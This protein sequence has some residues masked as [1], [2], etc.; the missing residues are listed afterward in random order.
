MI[1]KVIHVPTGKSGI[2]K[3]TWDALKNALGD[4]RYEDFHQ[5]MVKMKL[6]WGAYIT[7]SAGSG[8][9]KGR[10]APVQSKKMMYE[11][12]SVTSSP[13]GDQVL[14][15]YRSESP[16]AINNI[17]EDA[18]TK[19]TTPATEVGDDSVKQRPS[20]KRV[21]ASKKRKVPRKL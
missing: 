10:K 3:N 13:S 12:T 21:A 19:V 1:Y 2:G 15:V 7:R 14:T 9:I 17:E 18:L 11:V 5:N 16:L 8:K 4:K 20:T 6:V